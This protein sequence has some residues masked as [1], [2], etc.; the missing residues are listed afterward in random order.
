L[1]GI[2]LKTA[3][4]TDGTAR[5]EAR[6]GSAPR[7]YFHE[8]LPDPPAVLLPFDALFEI[9]VAAA[10]RLWHTLLNRKPRPN[11][12]VFSKQR[13]KR[14]ILALRALDAHLENATYREIADALFDL[15]A[16]SARSWKTHD[17]RDKAIRLVRLGSSLMLGGYR[18]LL[19]HPYRRRQ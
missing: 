8:T 14:L 11:T 7:V 5:S 1:S 16:M 17:L 13:C 18:D 10:L 4:A 12:A 2:S 9:R 15:S 3:F 6:T 19:L